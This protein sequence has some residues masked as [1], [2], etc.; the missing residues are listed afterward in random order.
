[1]TIAIGALLILCLGLYLNQRKLKKDLNYFINQQENAFLTQIKINETFIKT[2][3][4]VSGVISD[5]VR[6]LNMQKENRW[7]GNE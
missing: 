3:E 4:S 7:D 2:L 1:M 5:I 6:F